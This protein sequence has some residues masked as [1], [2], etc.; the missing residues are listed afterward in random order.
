VLQAEHV[1]QPD[2]P[3]K[4]RALRD[5]YLIALGKARDTQFLPRQVGGSQSA[6]ELGPLH[7]LLMNC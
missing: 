7:R 5:T 1:L 3:V 6:I 4:P 2:A